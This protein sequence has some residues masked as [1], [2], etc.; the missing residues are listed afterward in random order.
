MDTLTVRFPHLSDM[1]FDNLNN[2][3]LVSCKIVSK[4]WSIY[5]GEQKFYGIR[6]IEENVPKCKYQKLSKPWFEVFK[7]ANTETIMELKN[8]F[9]QFK[10]ARKNPNIGYEY[11]T[12]ITPLHV[13][14]CA[15]NILLY[16]SIH[17]LAQNKQPRCENGNEPIIYAINLGHVKMALFII[18]K[19]VDKNPKSNCGCTALHTA[20]RH[21]Y[22]EI[23]ESILKHLE[24]KNPKNKCEDVTPLHIAAIFG[25]IRVCE[26]IMKHIDEKNPK[27]A[28]G[29][30]PLHYAADDGRF[31]I[32]ELYLKTIKKKHPRTNDGNTPLHMAA[33]CGHV[34][35]CILILQSI[36]S[37]NPRNHDGKTP[38]TLARENEQF[39]VCW[40]LEKIWNCV[41]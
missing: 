9:G 23:F 40:L 10:E 5:I 34:K 3:S 27:D 19:M 33:A 36:K 37:K 11:N 26:F 22:V 31:D 38:L 2:Q 28:D 30:T 35:V 32:C 21:G 1:I 6:I 25:H 12:E 4:T 39:K 20:A 14:A 17:K 18:E 7:K 41:T 29:W 16:E 13:S 8:S 15:G 24:D